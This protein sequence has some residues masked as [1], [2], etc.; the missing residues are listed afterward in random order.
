M[1]IVD[2]P[3]GY[4]ARIREFEGL[5]ADTENR[6]MVAILRRLVLAYREVARIEICGAGRNEMA[7]GMAEARK[8]AASHEPAAGRRQALTRV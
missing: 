6:E 1:K 7:K 3:P 4:L 2:H 5:A 8:I